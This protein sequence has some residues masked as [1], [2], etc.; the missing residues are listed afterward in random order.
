MA[1]RKRRRNRA[2]SVQVGFVAPK[3]GVV[4]AIIEATELEYALP[5]GRVLFDDVSFRVGNK[6]HVALVGAN[7][8]GKTTLL[9]LIAGEDSA[10]RGWIRTDGRIRMMKQ[11]VGTFGSTTTVRDFLLEL[12]TQDVRLAARAIRD[13]ELALYSSGDAGRHD[14]YAMAL[15]SWGE[16]GGYEAEVLWDTCTT[17]A[18]GQS[19][20]DIA[21]R[22]LHLLSGGEQ[23]RLALESLLRSDAQILLL[24][25][26]D[27]FLD[28]PGKRWLEDTLNA[29]KKTVLYVSHDRA[30]L[31]NTA[32][33]VV[34]LEGRGAWTH[35][36]SFA[37]YPEARLQR[38]ERI[39]EERRRYDEEHQRLIASM[40]EFR[41]RA[42]LSDA[43]ASRL[44]ASVT[45]VERFE[46]TVVRPQRPTEQNIR[47]NLVGGRTGKLALKMIGL[48][49]PEIVMPFT[50]ELYFGERVGVV[51]PNGSGKSHLLRLLSGEPVR[52]QGEYKLGARVQ[53][54]LFSQL[55]ERPDIE[56]RPIVEVMMARGFDRSGA[57]SG[58]K[59]YELHGAADVSFTVLSGGQ[60]A[61]FQLLLMER[62][63]PTM[64]LLDEPTDNLDVESA[65]ALEEGLM[66][67]EGT[68]VAVTH[69][70]WFMLLMDRFLV[71]NSDGSVTEASQSPYLP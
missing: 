38:I 45:K 21:D 24:D 61:R 67:Y 11:F 19:F 46:R 49:F 20:E 63:S 8:V 70:R 39:D 28:I 3:N 62:D 35:P 29:S 26:P 7:G 14:R 54:R 5:G 1:D 9:R 30:L 22:P 60:Q 33:R 50:T 66:N 17:A 48:G 59:R 58:L 52:H 36:E 40:K 34:T 13:T 6:A 56:D 47:M 51:G 37:T 32:H 31:A 12:S 23:K 16:V 68:V 2:R 25:E 4:V 53:P 69:D 43:F 65:E 15:A 18:L 27:N 42:A 10:R 55:H 44:K 57:M 64:L 71:F 41:R